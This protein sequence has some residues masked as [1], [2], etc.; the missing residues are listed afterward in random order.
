MS[1]GNP[2][3]PPTAVDPAEPRKHRH[4]GPI[5][6]GLIAIVVATF[7][8]GGLGTLAGIMGVGSW[9][10][11]K[12]WP[13]SAAPEDEGAREFLQKLESSSNARDSVLRP[14]ESRSDE[15]ATDVLGKLQL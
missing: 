4:M 2:Y 1:E 14:S 10:V 8:L 7:L 3:R 9:W 12:F 13:R 5:L 15:P 11:Y 6:A